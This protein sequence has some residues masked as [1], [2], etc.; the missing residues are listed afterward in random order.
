MKNFKECVEGECK[1]CPGA[2]ETITTGLAMAGAE[3]NPVKM[4][5]DKLKGC[6]LGK[7]DLD[8]SSSGKPF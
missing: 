3:D 7:I 1:T 2:W 4:I 5:N 8:A 6:K